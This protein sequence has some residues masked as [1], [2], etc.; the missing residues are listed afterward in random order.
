MINLKARNGSKEHCKKVR[1]EN[2]T[3]RP[4]SKRPLAITGL[5]ASLKSGARANAHTLPT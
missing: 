4:K 5:I 2:P 1:S 3:N